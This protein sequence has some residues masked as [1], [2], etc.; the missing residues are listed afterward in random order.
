MKLGTDMTSGNI[1]KLMFSF[2]VPLIAQMMF[3][4]INSFISAILLGKFVGADA[5]GVVAMVMP[6]IFVLNSI[7]IG[8]TTAT[9]I[10]VAQVYGR[11]EYS[12]IKKI[13][14]TSFV[15]VIFTCI[16]C[17]VVGILNMNSLLHA[18]KTPPELLH[19]AKI[20][21][22][23]Q[24]LA[25]PLMFFQFLYFSALRG[26]GNS[27]ST[28][29]YQIVGVVLNLLLTPLFICGFWGLPKLGVL[30]AGL[31][32]AISQLI[33][34][35]VMLIHMRKQKSL[36]RLSFKGLKFDKEC[37]KLTVKIGFPTMIQQVILNISS[38]FIIGFVNHFGHTATSG[39]GAASRVDFIAF[40]PAQ[41]ICMTVSMVAGQNMGVGKFDRVKKIFF[42]GA[43]FGVLMILIPSFFAF[44]M[45]EQVM[46]IFI[47][48]TPAIEIG[49]G[50]L[51]HMSIGYI[52][53]AVMFAAEGIPLAS[54]QTW[55]ATAFTLV[56]VWFIRVPLANY[57]MKGKM[58]IDGIWLAMV[59]GLLT[60]AILGVSY[61]LS[62][63][64]KKKAILIDNN[65]NIANIETEQV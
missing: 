9:S 51:R 45:P 65:E 54:G 49:M 58:Q 16:I 28:M 6:I 50:Y 55:V 59:F 31:A 21:L 61:V 63:L 48:D 5:L 7:A 20:Y 44:L 41:A 12:N 17:V 33:L 30:G 64:W 3:V 40:M 53:L 11:K 25:T 60:G 42:W 39:F 27:K 23:V 57:L 22:F 8:L 13:I 36:L 46:K 18:I 47:N 32:M 34:D 19:D 15:L 52:F 37:G 43:L 56:S 62:G 26:I 1:P 35:I 10:L 2:S 38:L 29:Y 24:F 4:V 14:D